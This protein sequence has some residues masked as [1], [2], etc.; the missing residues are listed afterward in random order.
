MFALTQSWRLANRV[1][2]IARAANCR[3]RGAGAAAENYIRDAVNGMSAWTQAARARACVA[4]AA[5][6][7][8]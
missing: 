2:T 4:F 8:P 7:S 6:G 5:A 3:K 1:P